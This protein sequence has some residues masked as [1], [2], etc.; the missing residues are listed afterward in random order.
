LNGPAYR[1][2][3]EF[4]VS[5]TAGKVSLTASQAAKVRLD[6]GV[7]RPEWAAQARPVLQRRRSGGAADAVRNDVVWD[8]N[9]V[10]WQAT[11]GEYELLMAGK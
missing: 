4:E 11:P 1:R 2:P 5:W 9:A 10:E 8:G 3:A 6:Y 7:L